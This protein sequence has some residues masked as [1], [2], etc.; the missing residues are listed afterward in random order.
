MVESTKTAVFVLSTLI[1]SPEST[2]QLYFVLSNDETSK[3]L[4]RKKYLCDQ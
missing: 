4:S 2:K 1:F 3:V